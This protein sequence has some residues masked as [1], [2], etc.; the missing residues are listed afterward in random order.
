MTI[1]ELKKVLSLL[2]WNVTFNS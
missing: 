2:F 1:Q